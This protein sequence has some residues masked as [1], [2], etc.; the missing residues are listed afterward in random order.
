MAGYWV[1]S[2]D[3]E[4]GTATTSSLFSD[5]DEAWQYSLDIE[6]PATYTTVVPQRIRPGRLKN[7]SMLNRDCMS[8]QG[9]RQDGD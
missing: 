5:A 4:S 3:R 9:D 1:I 2:A 8:V 7:G 6:D